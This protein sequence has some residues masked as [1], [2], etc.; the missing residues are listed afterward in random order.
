MRIVGVDPVPRHKTLAEDVYDRL[1]TAIMTGAVKPG[2]KISARSVADSAKVSF[3][4][5]REAVARLI[6]EGALELAGPKSVMVPKVTREA[7]DEI[8]KVRFALEGMAAEAAAVNMSER[9]LAELEK[10]QRQYEK[11]RTKDDFADSLIVNEAFHF[12]IYNACGLPRVITF[13]EL[14]W[15]QIGPS[16]NLLRTQAPLSERPHDF[17]NEALAGLRVRDGAKVRDAIK[18]DIQFGYERLRKLIDA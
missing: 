16:F 17:H 5:A 12:A 1:R 6:T 18:A 8:T 9:D 2:E 14:L 4:P 3:T 10:I 13:I 15:L 11:I 7:L